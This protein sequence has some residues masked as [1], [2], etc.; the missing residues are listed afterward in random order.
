MPETSLPVEHLF[1]MS[2]DIG[3]RSVIRRGPAARVVVYVT[4]GQFSGPR[5]RGKIVP[6]S[7]ADWV[8]QREDG[9]YR[10]D[11]RLTLETDDSAAIFMAYAGVGAP[12]DGKNVIRSAPL[13]ET[14]D[15][16]YAWLNRVQA[17]A[18]GTSTAESVSYE[19]Y[20]LSV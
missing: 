20:G 16:R 2:I 7:G 3:G 14:G 15:E 12:V 11:V 10:L 4:G 13:F 19:V 6:N 1:S 18:L 5:L 8:T 17:I 9:S